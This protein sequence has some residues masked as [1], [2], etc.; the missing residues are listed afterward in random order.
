MK[1]PEQTALVLSGGGVYGAFEIGVMKALFAGASPVNRYKPLEVGIFSGTS[2]GAFNA[3]CMTGFSQQN[4]LDAAIRLESIWLE[5]IA[6]RPGVCG[7]G[8]FR[9][10]GTPEF[11]D[12]NCLRQPVAL[13]SRMARDGLVV[14][15]Y[16]LGRGLN[17]L[18]S[19]A[20]PMDRVTSTVNIESFVDPLPFQNLVNNAFREEDVLNSTKSLRLVATNWTTGMPEY[21]KNSDFASGHGYEIVRASA[22]LPGVFPPVKIHSDTYVDGGVTENTPLNS[23]LSAGAT[24]LHVIY[25][26]PKP[27][28]LPLKGQPDTLDTMLRV[29]YLL[30]AGRIE[31]DVVN[32]DQIN[33]GLQTLAKFQDGGNVPA[34]AA[35]A[36]AKIAAKALQGFHQLVTVHRY[37]PRGVLAG[38][39]GM[40]DSQLQTIINVIEAG[41][42]IALTHDCEESGCLLPE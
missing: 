37:Y 25:L 4:E 18:V 14:G 22:A 5:R 23:A 28:F 27:Q 31:Q 35:L 7:T 30:L 38:E 16:L 8:A 9:I 10:R 33:Q 6:D 26:N 39:F 19:P 24:E 11:I 40:L 41:E 20:P 32:L 42:N 2:V 17:F 29:F 34:N 3:A 21:F 12:P 13:A 15:R 1:P 36:F